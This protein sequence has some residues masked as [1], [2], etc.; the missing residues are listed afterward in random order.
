MKLINPLSLALFAIG[1]LPGF[2]CADVVTDWNKITFETVKAGGYNSNLGTRVG[3]IASIAVYDAANAASHFGTPYHFAGSSVDPASAPAAV[4]Q[5]AHDV[6][7]SLFP[8]QQVAIDTRL[9]ETLSSIPE[10]P[11]KTRGIA[12]GSASAAAVLALRAEDGSS[13]NSTYAGPV[14]PGVGEWRPTPGATTGSFPPGINKQWGG[15]KPFLLPSSGIFRVPPPPVVGTPDY[16][17]ALTEVES[18]GK[19]SSSVR[20][21]EQTHVAQFYKQDAELL[22]NEAARQLSAAASL[23]LEENALLLVLVN[24]AIADARIAIWESKYH[25]NY[26][27]PVTALNAEADGSITNGYSAWSPLLVT[28]AHPSYP[29]GHSGTVNAGVEVLKEF[30]GNRKTLVLQTTTPGE[31]ARV[32][33]SLNQIESE[34][35]LSRIY[36]GIH[37]SFDNLQGQDLGNKVAS[38][39]LANGPKL[40]VAAPTAELPHVIIRSVPSI[41]I[42]GPVGQSYRI[43]SSDDLTAPSWH[44]WRYVTTLGRSAS[45]VLVD[46]SSGAKRFYRAVAVSNTP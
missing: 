22:I 6:L 44:P 18:L 3:A 25:Y 42:Q 30:F 21:A 38:Y 4:A 19:S 20:T 12:L 46:P 34:N 5:A 41:V 26:W 39:V 32:V 29:S 33:T 35:G 36:G 2:I 31:P 13:P 16:Q 24:I 1:A 43:E 23:S 14:A 15:V 28:P 27:R 11:E 17:A 7:V 9:V 45:T 8:A 40:L 37:H 10:G